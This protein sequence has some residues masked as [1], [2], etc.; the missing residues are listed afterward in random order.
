MIT[1]TPSPKRSRTTVRNVRFTHT[2]VTA[3]GA[4]EEMWDNGFAACC[5]RSNRRECGWCDL[6][7]LI[8]LIF[9]K[10]IVTMM[11]WLLNS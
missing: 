4:S 6:R 10:S 9:N 1:S 2:T 3:V 7:G 11:T 8:R 5:S